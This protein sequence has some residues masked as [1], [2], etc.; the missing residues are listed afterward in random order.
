MARKAQFTKPEPGFSLYEGRT[1]GKKIRYTY[2][3]DEG[4][5]SET[6]SARRSERQSGISTPAEEG[7]T[8]TASGR[9]VRS[10]L[11]GAYGES[12]LSGRH[13][14]RIT[15]GPGAAEQSAGVDQMEEGRARRSG[16]RQEINGFGAGGDHIPGYNSVDEMDDEEDAA[17]SGGDDYAADDNVEVDLDDDNEADGEVSDEIDLDDDEQQDRSLVVQL[18][19]QKSP[20]QDAIIV[21]PVHVGAVAATSDPMLREQ[22]E[23]TIRQNG[24]GTSHLEE[25]H[26]LAATCQPDAPEK[27]VP[28]PKDTAPDP[29]PH[30]HPWSSNFDRKQ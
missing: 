4:S 27:Q 14:D 26:D 21:E 28:A 30:R 25:Q 22:G 9:Q 18:R 16:L 29:I 3:S 6:T 11:G 17:S 20:K 10:R 24:V 15:P 8:F 7:P 2:S 12:M 23:N 19:Y 13:S 1:R 5:G